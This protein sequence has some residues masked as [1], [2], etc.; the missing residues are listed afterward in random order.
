MPHRKQGQL[1]SGCSG[2]SPGISK[3]R[4]HSISGHFQSYLTAPKR[5]SCPYGCL[6]GISLAVLQPVS[7]ASPPPTVN[8]Q[9]ESGCVHYTIQL[10]SGKIPVRS[11]LYFLLPRLNKS[12]SLSL[13]KYVLQ[14]QNPLC[15]LAPICQLLGDIKTG[16]SIYTWF[17]KCQREKNNPFT[18]VTIPFPKTLFPL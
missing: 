14:N 18:P 8:F 10:G 4:F 2:P 3:D 12:S 15:Q 13:L 7:V 17:P 5:K 9:E 1:W 6:V 11:S 16:G